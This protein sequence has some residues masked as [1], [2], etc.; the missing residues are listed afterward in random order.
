MS[1]HL[2]C[3]FLNGVERCQRPCRSDLRYDLILI[4][5]KPFLNSEAIVLKS[6]LDIYLINE[7]PEWRSWALKKTGDYIQCSI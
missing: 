2:R 4:P 7:A 6:P 5:T 1:I 3:C